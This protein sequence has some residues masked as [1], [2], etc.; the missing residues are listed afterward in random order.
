MSEIK[1]QKKSGFGKNIIITALILVVLLLVGYI[2][3]TDFIKDNNTENNGVVEKEESKDNNK[4]VS[5]TLKDE[6]LDIAGIKLEGESDLS[7]G[8]LQSLF[9]DNSGVINEFSDYTKRIIIY[10]YSLK[11]NMLDTFAED[12]YD[13]LPMCEAGS[14]MCL[15]IKESNYNIIAKKYGISDNGDELYSANSS[16]GDYLTK[17]N[18]YYVLGIGGWAVESKLKHDEVTFK[19]DGDSVIVTDNVSIIYES[20]ADDKKVVTYTFNKDDDGSYYL[21]SVANRAI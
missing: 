11:H 4:E 14:G 7:G 19:Y 15:A 21:F 20:R 8:D 12:Y 17:Y 2:V 10:A 9:L 1:E 3:Y 16:V 13:E 18:D 5:Q 6:L